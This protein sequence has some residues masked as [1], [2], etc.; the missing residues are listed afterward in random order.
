MAP[1][2]AVQPDPSEQRAFPR[3]RVNAQAVW[4]VDGVQMRYAVSNLSWGGAALVVGPLVLRPGTLRHA[5]FVRP[6]QGLGSAQVEV[7]HITDRRMGL[8]F[9]E[10]DDALRRALEELLAELTPLA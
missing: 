1:R 5:R 9:L 8:R 7:V 3:Y 2:V 4:T 10:I 6:K